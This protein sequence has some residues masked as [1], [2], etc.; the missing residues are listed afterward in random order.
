MNELL[1]PRFSKESGVLCFKAKIAFH[2]FQPKGVN[3]I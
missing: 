2:T 3:R 1:K